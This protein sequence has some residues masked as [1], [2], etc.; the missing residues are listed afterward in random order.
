MRP[1][2]FLFDIDGTLIDASGVGRRAMEVAFVE[3]LGAARSA[4][5]AV[6]FAGATDRGIVRSGMRE[7]KL[8]EDEASID[9]VLARYLELLPIEIASTTPAYRIHGGV[10]EA[11]AIAEA[12][13]RGAVGLGTGNLARGAQIKLESVGLWDRFAF[14]GFGCDAEPRHEVLAAGVRRGAQRLGV[15]PAECRVLVIGD[16]P[17]DVEAAQAIGADCLGVTTGHASAE[18]LRDAGANWVVDRLDHPLALR[19]LG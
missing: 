9:A 13:A 2:I 4:I 8:P 3:V 15:D 6:K 11:I 7:A 5:E 1:S 10:V 19:A 18:E 12:H 16:T 17:R 14:G